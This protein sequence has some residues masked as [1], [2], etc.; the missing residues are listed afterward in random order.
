MIALLADSSSW[1]SWAPDWLRAIVGTLIAVTTIAAL[2]RKPPLTWIGHYI[3]WVARRL[4]GEPIAAFLD[5]HFRDEVVPIIEERVAPVV[6]ALDHLHDCVENVKERVEAVEQKQDKTLERLD[7]QDVALR[8][9]QQA[10][11]NEAG[12]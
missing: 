7:N 12:I 6:D 1:D 11:V 2:A 8:N 10:T 5:R 3:A 4:V 9:I